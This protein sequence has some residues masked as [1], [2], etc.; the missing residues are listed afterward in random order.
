MLQSSHPCNICKR[1]IHQVPCP[2]GIWWSLHTS[3]LEMMLFRCKDCRLVVK[4]GSR[5]LK[6]VRN[7][8][9]RPGSRCCKDQ[10]HP[11]SSSPMLRT[12]QLNRLKVPVR[13]GQRAM[14]KGNESKPTLSL[15]QTTLA[16]IIPMKEPEVVYVGRNM[17]STYPMG[18][19][20]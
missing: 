4:L 6:G 20:S 15:R 3:G 11:S 5:Y 10:T 16:T 19:K 9:G 13:G 7:Q 2:A 17:N 18:V 12:I 14:V 8:H 1:H